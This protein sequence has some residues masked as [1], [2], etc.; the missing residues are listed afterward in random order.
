MNLRARI[1]SNPEMENVF[2]NCILKQFFFPNEGFP[3]F[4]DL[5]SKLRNGLR[6]INEDYILGLAGKGG[7][8]YV[9]GI[10]RSFDLVARGEMGACGFSSWCRFPVYDVDFGQ[11]KPVWVCP[12][13]CPEKNVTFLMRTRDGNGIEAWVN[14]LESTSQILE[15]KF[16]F[17]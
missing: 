4:H 8:D 10:S 1:K 17:L 16:K 5:F 6:E 7:D 13:S 15:T 12:T 3:Q 9:R 11:G 2:G 14:M